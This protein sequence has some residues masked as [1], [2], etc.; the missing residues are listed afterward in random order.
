ME[1]TDRDRDNVILPDQ[2]HGKPALPGAEFPAVP[3]SVKQ[4]VP[5]GS[6]A[7]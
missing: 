6:T 1:N 3:N 7:P 2:W 4:N 5:L